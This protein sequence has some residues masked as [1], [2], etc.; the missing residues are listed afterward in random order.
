MRG[1][2]LLAAYR[3]INGERRDQY[4]A[5]ENSFPIIAGFWTQYIHAKYPNFGL[6]DETDVAVM[7]ILLKIARAANGYKDDTWLDIAGYTGIGDDLASG[8]HET[9][10]TVGIS[11]D[12]DCAGMCDRMD[13]IPDAV[14]YNL[15]PVRPQEWPMD[16]SG[17]STHPIKDNEGGIHR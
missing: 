8:T 10:S 2:I 9:T 11:G 13:H 14:A 1:K 4:G 12:A 5:P 6:L 15:H 17:S 3:L 16:L 7:M